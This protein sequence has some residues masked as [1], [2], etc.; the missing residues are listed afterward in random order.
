[1]AL[2][3]SDGE[4]GTTDQVTKSTRFSQ[5]VFPWGKSTPISAQAAAWLEHTPV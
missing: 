4:R 3:F 5:G 1:M 2:F